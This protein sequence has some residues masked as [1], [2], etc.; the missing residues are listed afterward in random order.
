[1]VQPWELPPVS[2]YD[3]LERYLQAELG[4]CGCANPDA[5]IE[6]LRDVLRCVRNVRSAM[7]EEPYFYERSKQAYDRLQETLHFKR[8][9]GTAMWFLYLL[10]AHGLTEHGNNVRECWISAK[11][12][13][14]L[15][16]IER[17]Y[18]PPPP[19]ERADV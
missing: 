13:Q 17:Y 14:L 19:E 18:S 16:A 11:G 9:P 10:D 7:L 6:I 5:A 2:S 15:D 1:M 4:Y 12:V 8:A 3:E